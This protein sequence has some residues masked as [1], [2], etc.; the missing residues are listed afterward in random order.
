MIGFVLKR[1]ISF[2]R[3]IWN[4]GGFL[5]SNLVAL[6][7]ADWRRKQIF[8]WVLRDEK[9][10]QIKDKTLRTEAKSEA[11]TSLA[12]CYV[13]AGGVW[14][15]SS[16]CLKLWRDKRLAEISEAKQSLSP[17]RNWVQINSEGALPIIFLFCSTSIIKRQRD[18]LVSFFFL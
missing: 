6:S 2:W 11:V 16:L 10:S 7:I 13:E 14:L 15:T 5:I 3:F 18:F 17:S 12:Q 9:R 4:S 8:N 1:F